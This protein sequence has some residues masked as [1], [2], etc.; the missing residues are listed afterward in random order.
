MAKNYIHMGLSDD[1]YD[2]VCREAFRLTREN[3]GRR[4][5]KQVSMGEAVEWIIRQRM[6]AKEPAEVP[7]RLQSD[8]ASVG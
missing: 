2:Y 3:L 7:R 1:A 6:D 5:A 8:A 4:S